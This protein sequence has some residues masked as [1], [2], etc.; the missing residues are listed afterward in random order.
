MN[1]AGSFEKYGGGPVFGDEST[2]TLFDAFV[3]E[4]REYIGY[5]EGRIAPEVRI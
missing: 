4:D 2:G 3:R 5:A 1:H